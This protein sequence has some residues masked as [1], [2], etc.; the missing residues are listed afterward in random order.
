MTKS[1]I[2]HIP[3]VKNAINYSKK[4][5]L[6]G[7][8]GVPIYEVMQFFIQAMASGTLSTRGSAM[9]FSF[10]MATF[11]AIIF[12]FSLLPHIPIENLQEILLTQLEAILPHEAYVLSKETIQDIINQPRDGLLSLGFFMALI[13]STNGTNAMIEGFNQSS[14]KRAKMSYF[15]QRLFALILFAI[16]ATLTLVGMS[17]IILNEYVIEYLASKQVMISDFKFYLFQSARWIVIIA[18]FY[19]N[20]SFVYAFAPAVKKEW[21]FFTAGSTITTVMIILTSLGFSYYINNFGQYNK[22]YGS[23]GTLL[24]I[25]LWLYLVSTFI[26]IGYELN[27]SISNAK[28]TRNE[29]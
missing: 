4:I 3:I 13:F 20:I 24:V 19:F 15:K 25:M 23:I 21:K 5:V 1:G 7:F 6:P 14:I 17:L 27:A 28:L 12:L 22:L 29:N 2:Q 8:N 18:L 10:F 11:P 16:I 9:A 26:L